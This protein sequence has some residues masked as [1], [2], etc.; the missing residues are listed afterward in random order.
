MASMDGLKES[1]QALGAEAIA[2]LYHFLELVCRVD[3]QK[4]EGNRTRIERLLC[5]ADHHGGILADRIQHHRA[6]EFGG[7]FSYDVNAFGFQ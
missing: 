1:K 7:H 3:M 4:R 5:Q 2:E 6:L